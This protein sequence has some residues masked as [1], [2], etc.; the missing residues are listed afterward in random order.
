MFCMYC[1]FNINYKKNRI[2][3]AVKNLEYWKNHFVKK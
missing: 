3:N 1:V 2:G